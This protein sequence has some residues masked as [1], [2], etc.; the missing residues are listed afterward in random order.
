MD[1]IELTQSA[2]AREGSVGFGVA[3]LL[4]LATSPRVGLAT[5]D[6]TTNEE[7]TVE[8]RSGETFQVSGEMWQLTEVRDP[9][10]PDWVVVLRRIG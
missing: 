6:F 8:L 3:Y 7:G 9:T 4:D 5:V 10:E 2:F 1:D